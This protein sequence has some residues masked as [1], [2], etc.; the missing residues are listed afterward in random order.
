[1][2]EALIGAPKPGASQQYPCPSKQAHK[3]ESEKD[4]T[5]RPL[6]AAR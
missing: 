2:A 6:T 4:G 1:M 5:H 3:R